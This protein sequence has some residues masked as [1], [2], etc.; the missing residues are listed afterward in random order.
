MLAF[1]DKAVRVLCIAAHF[2]GQAWLTWLGTLVVLGL[3]L[4]SPGWVAPLLA[5][6][7]WKFLLL[8]REAGSGC[9]GC[10]TH[11]S[12]LVQFQEDHMGRGEEAQHGDLRGVG[13]VSPWPRFP[14]RIARGQGHWY[15]PAQPYFPPS[16]DGQSVR[17][18]PEVSEGTLQVFC[19]EDVGWEPHQEEL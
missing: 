1:S 13:K 6:S 14:G 5:S 11:A 10:L 18:Q 17:G 19:G 9:P 7:D 2:S 3:V 15:D 8:A 16:W 4:Q 12:C